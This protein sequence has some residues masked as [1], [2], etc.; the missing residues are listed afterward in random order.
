[1]SGESRGSPASAPRLLVISDR[2][3]MGC[4]PLAAVSQ[5]ARA[6]LPAFQW[7]EKDLAAGATYTFLQGLVSALRA[8]GEPAALLVNDRIDIALALGIGAHLPE[9]ALPTRIARTLLPAGTLIGRSTHSRRSAE[10]ARDEG[11]D[12]VTFGPVFDTPSKRA[13][14]PPQGVEAL[15]EVCEA[16]PGFPVLAIGGVTPPRMRA[17]REAGAHGVAVIGAIWNASD[18]T[19]ACRRLL[20]ELS[21]SAGKAGSAPPHS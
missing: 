11:A 5:L 10:Q 7:R 16:L 6:G 14:G 21:G 18:P 4:D 1:M 13:Y 17:C 3:R 8:S 2:G 19:A 20:D 9:G 12:Y 15:R